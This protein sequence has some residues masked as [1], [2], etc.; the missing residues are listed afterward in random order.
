MIDLQ[1]ISLQVAEKL[2]EIATRHDNVPYRTGELRKAHV[3]Q[4]HG[5]HDAVLSA[6]TPYARPVHDG[7]PAVTI[8]PKRKRALYWNTAAHPVRVVRQPARSG[9]PWLARAVEELETEGLD[10]LAPQLGR[11]VAD[12]LA[13]ALRR[14]GL[15]VRAP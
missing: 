7:R 11:D 8:R 5:A 9:N 13:E 3:V 14:R 12:Q 4:P 1:S 10:F 15:R 6:N 2:R